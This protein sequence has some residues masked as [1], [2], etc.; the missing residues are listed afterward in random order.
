MNKVV[1]DEPL[2]AKLQGLA[3]QVELHDESGQIL[4]QFLPQQVYH[5]LVCE[6]AKAQVSDDELDRIRREPGGRTTAE[7]LQ[8]L[9]SMKA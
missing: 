2:R 3:E 6:W 5:R 4:G 1:L 7:V 8:R 9:K